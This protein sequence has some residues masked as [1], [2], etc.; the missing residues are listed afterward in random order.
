FIAPA[1]EAARVYDFRTLYAGL[2]YPSPDYFGSTADEVMDLQ[3]YTSKD[4]T[5]YGEIN[6]YLRYHPAPY[7]WYGTGPEDAKVIVKRLDRIMGRAPAIPGDIV[8]FRGLGLGWH[9]NKP[10]ADGEEFTDK[11]YVS[12]SV[13]YEVARYFAVEKDPDEAAASRRAVFAVYFTRPAERGI[14]IDQG[15]AEV[16]LERGRKFRVMAR[17]DGREEFDLYL[18]QACAVKCET[19]LKPDAAAF[20][21]DLTEENE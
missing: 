5:Y 9:G 2:G 12:T 19:A 14:L 16:M 7:E 3:T 18:V 11:G 13:S 10:F 4:D 17:A 8:L 1:A 15:E 21:S 6:G 20:W